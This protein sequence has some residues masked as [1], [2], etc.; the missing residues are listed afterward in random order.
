MLFGIITICGRTSLLYALL[1]IFQLENG[2]CNV[3]AGHVTDCGVKLGILLN[4]QRMWM[5]KEALDNNRKV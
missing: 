1:K 3:L 2:H 5:E 4:T